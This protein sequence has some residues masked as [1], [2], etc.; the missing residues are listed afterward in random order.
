MEVR[1]YKSTPTPGGPDPIRGDVHLSSE[2]CE[3]LSGILQAAAD[4]VPADFV[5]LTDRTGQMIASVGTM[6]DHKLTALGSLMAADFAANEEIGRLF[7]CGET[8]SRVMLRECESSVILM[9]PAGP[10]LALLIHASN[11]VAG[12]WARLVAL[13]AVKQITEKSDF[14]APA[15]ECGEGGAVPDIS[16]EVEQAFDGLWMQ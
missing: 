6:S 5:I 1:L 13:D 10:R 7:G 8:E 3:R 4:R 9:L 15:N 2:E 12:G 11:S 16:S 14:S